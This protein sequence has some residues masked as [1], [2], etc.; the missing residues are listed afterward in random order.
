MWALGSRHRTMKW[1]S[2][3]SREK[4]D[5]VT[6]GVRTSIRVFYKQWTLYIILFSYMIF[7]WYLFLWSG[8]SWNIQEYSSSFLRVS[9]SPIENLKWSLHNCLYFVKTLL[10]PH[11]PTFL[12]SVSHFIFTGGK[13]AEGFLKEEESRKTS[14]LMDIAS[15][16]DS[17]YMQRVIFIF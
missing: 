13:L 16:A 7:R 5:T 11:S 3:D 6:P 4:I 15:L 1:S 8:Y 17:N 12:F 10:L 9:H 14:T 2:W